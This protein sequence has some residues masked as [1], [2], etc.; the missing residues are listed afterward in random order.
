MKNIGRKLNNNNGASILIALIFL[1]VCITV[2]LIILTAA[3]SSSGVADGMK[4]HEQDYFTVSS[5]AQLIRHELSGA[6]FT[7]TR[8]SE[9]DGSGEFGAAKVTDKDW[10][11]GVLST[12]LGN[13][14]DKRLVE[15][16]DSADITSSNIFTVEVKTDDLD[17]IKLQPV[18]GK[19][20][21][22]ADGTIIITLGCQTKNPDKS[23]YIMTLTMTPEPP[24]TDTT[25]ET[26]IEE[27][28]DTGPSTANE[29]QVTE[30][31]NDED[32]VEQ[33]TQIIKRTKTEVTT[34]RWTE[35]GGVIT[36]GGVL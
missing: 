36:K 18:K 8:K 4:K 6:T 1:L 2:G 27:S 29:S 13:L 23:K 32:K 34:Y 7:V 5:A 10:K 25:I 19:V 11:S 20:D 30:T 9:D 17:K 28:P 21:M 24:E 31:Q 12:Q 35:E 16:S 14:A 33:G 26:V 15:Q 3:S 22:K